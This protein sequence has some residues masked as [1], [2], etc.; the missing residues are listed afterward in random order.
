MNLVDARSFERSKFLREF[1]ESFLFGGFFESIVDFQIGESTI[2]FTVCRKISGQDLPKNFQKL[3]TF[4]IAGGFLKVSV[5]NTFQ[6]LRFRILPILVLMEHVVMAA[7]I[8]RSREMK[9]LF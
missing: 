6:F 2:H 9:R 1:V 7:Y 8:F 5:Q 4:K 3:A